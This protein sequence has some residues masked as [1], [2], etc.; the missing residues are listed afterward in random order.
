MNENLLNIVEQIKTNPYIEKRS[1]RELDKWESELRKHIALLNDEE[2]LA[3]NNVYLLIFLL[4][5]K[6]VTE[7]NAVEY[8]EKIVNYLYKKEAKYKDKIKHAKDKKERDQIYYQL[9]YFY[10]IAELNVAYLENQFKSVKMHYLADRAYIDKITLF[11]KEQ[12]STGRI[13]K[14]LSYSTLFLRH[15][16]RK[17]IVLYGILSYVGI[18]LLW[19]GGWGIIEWLIFLLNVKD[20]YAYLISSILGIC[21]LLILG[22]FYDQTFGGNKD[23]LNE[24]EKIEIS[25]IEELERVE[26]LVGNKK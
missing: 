23:S 10:K 21:I 3:L 13:G 4:H 2:D 8:Y 20:I 11:K 6:R 25:G 24:M 12:L 14:Y 17:N 16:L 1:R 15:F 26:R 19:V 18:M 22:I 7:K 9:I 5:T